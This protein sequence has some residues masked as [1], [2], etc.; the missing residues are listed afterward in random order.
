MLHHE[1]CELAVEVME[2]DYISVAHLVQHRDKVAFSVCSPL[3]CLHDRDVGDKTV[4]ANRIIVDIVPNLLNQTVVPDSHIAKGRIID[5]GM[6]EESFCYL[7]IFLETSQPDVTIEHDTVEELRL[8]SLL[9]NLHLAP[10]FCPAVVILQCLNLFT[11]KGT[12]LHKRFL[13]VVIS[14]IGLISLISPITFILPQ[15][16][17]G[18]HC[19]GTS[20]RATH[21]LSCKALP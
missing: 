12:V 8:E 20:E 18:N 9:N 13:L 5:A 11:G 1:S 17:K 14:L 16:C 21:A 15:C 19:K 7:N 6:F 10:V 2:E 4:V 3:R